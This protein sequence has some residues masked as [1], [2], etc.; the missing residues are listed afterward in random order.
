METFPQGRAIFTFGVT[1]ALGRSR[2]QSTDGTNDEDDGSACRGNCS[3]NEYR[4]SARCTKQHAR[5]KRPDGLTET[6][7]PDPCCNDRPPV[8]LGSFAHCDLLQVRDES[9]LSESITQRPDDE[10]CENVSP[11]DEHHAHRPKTRTDRKR[12]SHAHDSPDTAEIE[13]NQRRRQ[14]GNTDHEASPPR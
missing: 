7:E 11:T 12:P 9:S 2:R 5:K 3:G 4:W 6:G 8:L 10:H 1:G 14:C 13:P